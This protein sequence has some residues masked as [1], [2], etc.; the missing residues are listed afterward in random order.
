M[1]LGIWPLTLNI[2]DISTHLKLPLKLVLCQYLWLLLC[3]WFGAA[4]VLCGS[5]VISLFWQDYFAEIKKKIFNPFHATGLYAPW[6]HQKTRGSVAW[7][8]WRSHQ[9]P[10]KPYK[11][12]F[13]FLSIQTNQVFYLPSIF[14]KTI[15]ESDFPWNTF[16][17]ISK[18]TRV[19]IKSQNDVIYKHFM[20]ML[21]QFATI[22]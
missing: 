11:N 7:N 13:Q 20:E 17:N 3:Y 18:K 5:D 15:F 16:T 10:E 4:F 22:S 2:Y 14:N 1:S 8:G 9:S 19:G 21:A 12:S 6:T